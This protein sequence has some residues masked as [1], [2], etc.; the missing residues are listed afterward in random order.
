MSELYV[1]A[2]T[3]ASESVFKQIA[4]VELSRDNVYKKESPYSNYKIAIIFGLTGDTKGQI[5][6]NLS[7]EAVLYIASL[8]MGGMEVSEID[9]ITKSAI[10]ELGNMI[11]GNTSTILYNK[12]IFMDISV[13]S[14][15]IGENIK[16][17][18]STNKIEIICIPFNIDQDS[19]KIN[20][21]INLLLPN[22]I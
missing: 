11:L 6:F 18:S 16:I 3:E 17:S 22:K 12:S 9:D 1:E 5:I 7:E 2:L 10:S 21:E 4:G 19:K 13:P 15:L 20:I 14:F 8:M